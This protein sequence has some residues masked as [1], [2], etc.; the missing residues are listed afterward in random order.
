MARKLPWSWLLS[1]SFGF[2]VAG[3]SSSSE[4]AW[5]RLIT[6]DVVLEE[7]GF[8]LEL[9]V[10]AAGPPEAVFLGA[11]VY[12]FIEKREEGVEHKVLLCHKI[13]PLR[14]SHQVRHPTFQKWGVGNTA[15]SESV[16]FC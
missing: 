10:V 1:S 2:L 13:R 12:E 6:T 3:A 5:P 11:M 15:G 9:L 7:T 4:S 8:A 16:P 14:M